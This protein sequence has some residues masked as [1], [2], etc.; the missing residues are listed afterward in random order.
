MKKNF[1][2]GITLEDCPEG[3]IVKQDQ[4]S[5]IARGWQ[6]TNEVIEMVDCCLDAGMR[7]MIRENHP[8]RGNLCP[9]KQ[10][11]VYLAFSPTRENHWSMAIDS[12]NSKRLTF[13]DGVFNGKY[14]SQF[15]KYKIPFHFEKRNKSSGHL[16]VKRNNLFLAIKKLIILD[17]SVLYFKKKERVNNIGF[18]LET[19]IKRFIILN[20][21]KT[22][23]A[24]QELIRDE[25]PV[26]NGFNPERVDLL[27]FNKK[28][29]SYSVIELKR[30]EALIGDLDQVEGYC[31][32]LKEKNEFKNYSFDPVL[33]AERI[34]DKIK[35]KA[36]QKKIL[37][38]EIK[39]P[40][41]FL[42]I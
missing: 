21:K 26:T 9:N 30:A 28:S 15:N 8:Q 25:Y 20:W 29:K 39:W 14:H 16:I 42:Q 13:G 11:V 40:G 35:Q 10:G 7:W 24:D 4:I 12:F 2:F 34:S 5:Y 32:K 22:P 3:I 18:I 19:D 37:T 23:F 41:K 33:I 31:K 17:H 36:S 27:A 38:Y 6:I 1:R